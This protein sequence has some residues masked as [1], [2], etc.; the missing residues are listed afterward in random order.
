LANLPAPTPAGFLNIFNPGTVT[1]YQLY[2][3][4]QL[5]ASPSTNTVA[6]GSITN[7]PGRVQISGD[8]F[9]NLSNAEITGQ[10][11]MSL[12]STNNFAGSGGALI[13]TP[14]ADINLGQKNG[15]LILT[16]VMEASLPFLGGTI[17]AWNT[18]WV[19]VVHTQDF[20]ILIIA[21]QITPTIA[22]QV[23][24]LILRDYSSN[25]IVI[26][27]TFNVMRSF[28]TDCQSLTLTT[29]PPGFGATSV[30]GELNLESPG[31][32]MNSSAPNLR[33]LT[34]NGAVR[35]QNLMYFA[36]PTLTNISGGTTSVV[37]YLN[38]SALINNGIFM[39]Q[40]SIIYAGNFESSGIFSNG[41]GSF[42]LQSLT[43]TLTNGTLQAAGDVSI[44]TSSLITS[45]LA[46]QASRSLTLQVTNLLTDTGVTNG[47][48]WAVGSASVAYG[49]SLP[50][51]PVNGGN[52]LGTTI[53]L[54]A[55]T[56]RSVA[57]VWAAHDYG[58]ST[59]GYTN[60]EA[61]GRLRLD[62]A[63]SIISGHNGSFVFNAAGISNALY[64]DLLV[65]TNYATQGSATNN[66]N[67]PWLHINTNMFIYYAR[68]VET[69]ANGLVVDD[70]Q[71]ID[72]QSKLGA[73]GG[74]LR[75]ISSYAG[76]YSSTNLI[77]TNSSGVVIT[78]TINAALA[79]SSTIDSD[80]DGLV[81]SLD[82]TPFFLA[83]EMNFTL[84]V[85]NVPP[86]TAKIQWSTIPNATNFVYYTTN[87][88]S[89]NWLAYTNF[90]NWYYGNNVA[91]TNSSHGNSFHSPQVYLGANPSAPDNGTQT[92]V[93]VFDSI[94][95]VPHYYKVVV[96]P[97][98]DFAP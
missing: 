49:I 2:A 10:S 16:N 76:Y 72:N 12:I 97:W 35:M 93:W 86:N 42:T 65:L 33:Y 57:N 85:T 62:A 68:A 28:N 40:G 21:S 6:N 69:F 70:S 60:N 84:L 98:V 8:N 27:D 5:L 41:L 24:N 34:N 52:L 91:V 43:T 15:I 29:N 78:N 87:L 90:K 30:D 88:L 44:T 7:L 82:P 58:I 63:N 47:N 75:W 89:T 4:I 79:Q 11:Y 96:W 71:A 83:S 22:A 81:N 14:Y 46:L 74:R 80:G 26:S 38:N 66:F 13:R 9:L 51:F 25:N 64:V 32:F 45:N 73:N 36:Y 20:R 56:N 18:R 17:Q 54:S 95:N 31:I 3:N 55:P 59:A 94:T 50:Q 92:N 23:Q 48:V 19:D 1:N 53:T 39:D 67:F 77:Y 37:S 61:V